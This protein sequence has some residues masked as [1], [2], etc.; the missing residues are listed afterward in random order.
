MVAINIRLSEQ[1]AKDVALLK[2]E[3]VNISNV[4]RAALRDAAANLR[5]RKVKNVTDLNKIISDIHARYP[6]PV[7]EYVQMGIDPANR[8]QASAYIRTR[9]NRRAN[10]RSAI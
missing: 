3:G 9:L 7:P 10:K 8:A 2:R 6:G 5:R 1:D 4:A